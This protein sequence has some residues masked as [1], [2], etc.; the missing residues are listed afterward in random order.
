MKKRSSRRTISPQYDSFR[1]KVNE[2]FVELADGPATNL[3]D[4]PHAIRETVKKALKQSGLPEKSANDIAFH[5]TDWNYD[6]AFLVAVHLF[7]KRF[8]AKEIAAGVDCMLAHI[9]AHVIAAARLLGYSTED[10]FQKD[11]QL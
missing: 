6:A 3:K 1:R 10:F 11:E 5:L 7:P 8:T 9:P 2:I 4:V